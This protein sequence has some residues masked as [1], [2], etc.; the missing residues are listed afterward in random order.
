MFNL[1]KLFMKN[2]RKSSDLK[3]STLSFGDNVILAQMKHSVESSYLHNETSSNNDIFETLG[4]ED[5]QSFCGKYYGYMS[6][7]GDFPQASEDDY[8]ALTRL[9]IGLMKL[10]EIK[11]VEDALRECSCVKNDPKTIS[12]VEKAE[13][14]ERILH[15]KKPSELLNKNTVYLV[16]ELF[17]LAE[18]IFH[19]D[20]AKISAK[21]ESLKGK[22][23]QLG[24]AIVFFGVN[25]TVEKDT[26]C[27]RKG[28]YLSADGGEDDDYVFD[29]LGMT[30]REKLAFCKKHY[31]YE[32]EAMAFPEAR[33]DDFK[34][35]TRLTIAIL[36][37]IEKK[38]EKS[39]AVS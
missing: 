38:T 39:E 6:Q 35:L 19:P 34:G 1:N 18:D 22:T 25:Y 7:G 27:G 21:S 32:N 31:G 36:E 5:S 8:A 10:F 28:L 16:R 11:T 37:L 9:A 29:K 30:K 14:I 12:L 3:N 24:N 15:G 33:I 20:P 17:N 23:L 2:F 13:M 26:S 4:I